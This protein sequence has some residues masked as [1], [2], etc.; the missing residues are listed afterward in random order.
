[1][2]DTI[3]PEEI[4]LTEKLKE[5]S[6]TALA[7]YSRILEQPEALIDNTISLR[8]FE[9]FRMAQKSIQII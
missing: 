4:D 3:T 1:M 7:S 5:F 8:L 2:K 9:S 6:S